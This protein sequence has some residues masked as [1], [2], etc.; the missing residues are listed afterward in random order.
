MTSVWSSLLASGIDFLD[1]DHEALCRHLET[2][3]PG[4][5]ETQPAVFAE[6]QACLD[7]HFRAEEEEMR[8][9]GYP[10]L[11]EH[12]EDHRQFL[13]QMDYF[14]AALGSGRFRRHGEV[15]QFVTLW[16]ISHLLSADR[17]LALHIRRTMPAAA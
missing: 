2:L 6:L 13:E 8:R 11:A 5:L 3:S 10:G 14:A 15:L 4:Q 1:R 9:L 17:K 16:T 12:R 7:A